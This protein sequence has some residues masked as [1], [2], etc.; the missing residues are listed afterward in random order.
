MFA[1][2]ML[3]SVFSATLVAAFLLAQPAVFGQEATEA[4]RK[5]KT[6]VAPVYPELAKRMNVHGK[7]RLE[8][9]VAQDGKVKNIRLLGGHPLLA[10]AAQSAVQQWK[11]EPGPKETLQIVECN[12][13]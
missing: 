9:T 4:A 6:Q 7:V 8:V 5:V 10:T 1:R 13:D 12:F 3:H 11:F 2:S